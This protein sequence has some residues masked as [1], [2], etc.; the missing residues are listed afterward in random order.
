MR[1]TLLLA[2]FS[3]L[4]LSPTLAQP[5][6][7]G[8]YTVE[9]SGDDSW[10]R[11]VMTVKRFG[12]PVKIDFVLDL[13]LGPRSRGPKPYERLHFKSFEVGYEGEDVTFEIDLEAIKYTFQLYPVEVRGKQTFAGIVTITEGDTERTTGVLAVKTSAVR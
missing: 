1:R 5:D 12:D 2:L 11:N 9:I 6:Y 4:F 3:F 13:N 8:N 7:T 10:H